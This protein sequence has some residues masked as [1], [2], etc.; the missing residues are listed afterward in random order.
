[1][2][3]PIV[4]TDPKNDALDP[5]DTRQA[6]QGEPPAVPQQGDNDPK[7]DPMRKPADHR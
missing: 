6:Q 1:M 4:G 3:D 7:D 5:R 2:E